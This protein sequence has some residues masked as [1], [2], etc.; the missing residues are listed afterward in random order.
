M[1]EM[2][3][4]TSSSLQDPTLPVLVFYRPAKTPSRLPSG[5]GNMTPLSSSLSDP[6]PARSPSTHFPPVTTTCTEQSPCT[7]TLPPYRTP[8]V[9]LFTKINNR[10]VAITASTASHS[11]TRTTPTTTPSTTTTA[12]PPATTTTTASNA[13]TTTATSAST[14]TVTVT[15]YTC[16]TVASPLNTEPVYPS[17]EV[18]HPEENPA[19]YSSYNKG[20]VVMYVLLAVLMLF[21][22][23]VLHEM[24]D[25][26]RKEPWSLWMADAVRTVGGAAVRRRVQS[27]YGN[28]VA[29][30]TLRQGNRTFFQV[31]DAN[32]TSRN[33]HRQS[34]CPPNCG[35]MHA[36]HHHLPRENPDC[37]NPRSH[38]RPGRH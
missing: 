22:L 15:P 30:R 35:V 12:T 11:P 8:H 17:T 31:T 36:H 29:L 1:D 24:V 3:S 14:I 7:P 16:S 34:C 18:L 37:H 25:L 19:T 2:L 27:R 20:A 5:P 21:L 9:T 6:H 13:T 10:F 33:P 4:E 38:T 32:P 26:N 28:V 23:V